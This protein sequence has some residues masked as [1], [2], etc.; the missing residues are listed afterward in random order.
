M[1][2][3]LWHIGHCRLHK[4]SVTAVIAAHMTAIYKLPISSPTPAKA[5]IATACA[6][7]SVSARLARII[8]GKPHSHARQL[9]RHALRARGLH[10][11]HALI[12]RAPE[13]QLQ[14]ALG[15]YERPIHKHIHLVKQRVRILAL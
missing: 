14:R 10:V 1:E 9:S 15:Q 6:L 7:I 3:T 5:P 12:A 2:S 8:G 13:A 4:R 11:Q